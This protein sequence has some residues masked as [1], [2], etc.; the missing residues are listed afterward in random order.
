MLEAA[1]K[2]VTAAL[3]CEHR[4]SGHIL[5]GTYVV[6]AWLDPSFSDVPVSLHSPDAVTFAPIVDAVVL[7]FGC[8]KTRQKDVKQA[9][10]LIPAE[11]FLG[12]VRNYSH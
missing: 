8:G 1:L 2:M 11:K 5:S 4:R 9:L 6:F 12:F 7:V 3:V 10:S